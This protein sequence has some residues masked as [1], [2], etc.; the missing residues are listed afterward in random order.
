[1][2]YVQVMLERKEDEM[3]VGECSE[4]YQASMSVSF[5]RMFFCC[6]KVTLEGCTLN[7]VLLACSLQLVCLFF[8]W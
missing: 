3:D 4:L 8:L 7:A 1:M 6:C 5:K 2:D